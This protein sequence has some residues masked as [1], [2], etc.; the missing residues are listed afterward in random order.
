VDNREDQALAAITEIL[1]RL[2][3]IETKL[4]KFMAMRDVEPSAKD[5]YS[6]PK[7]DHQH[8]VRYWEG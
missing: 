7:Y 5:G 4:S 6:K 2:T 1:A 3:R 8:P